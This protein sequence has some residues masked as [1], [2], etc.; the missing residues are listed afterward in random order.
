MLNVKA[1]ANA[2]A[3]VVTVFYVVCALLSYIAQDLIFTISR[4]WMHSINIESIKT[5]G[6]PD[7]GLLIIG[8]VTL[9]GLTW[10][11]VYGTVW[12]YNRWAK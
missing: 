9:V 12:L 1:F 5:T 10:V 8:F 6:N 2:A 4:S 3:V 11:T 7:L